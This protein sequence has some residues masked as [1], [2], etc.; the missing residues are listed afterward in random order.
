M[1]GRR[2]VR[3]NRGRFASTG[4]TARGGRLATA[5]GNKRATQTTKIAGGGRPAGTVGRGGRSMPTTAPPAASSRPRVRGDF[6]PRNTMAKPQAERAEFGREREQNLAAAGAVA[7][8]HGATVQPVAFNRAQ[9]RSGTKAYVVTDKQGTT[10][11]SIY[12]NK[13]SKTWDNPRRAAINSRRNG[14]FSTS[15]PAGVILH[16]VGH[17]KNGVGGA[18]FRQV[19]RSLQRRG[20]KQ[21]GS[22]DLARRVSKYATT[23]RDEFVAETFAGLKTGRKYD[24]QVMRAY[25]AATG[26]RARSVRSQLNK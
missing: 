14:Q 1:A 18:S 6:R 20:L 12:V 8:R 7:R 13:D 5:S 10:Y 3:D 11:S 21:P 2:Y 22:A 9:L 15:S 4:A 16:E 17:I 19:D 26:R 24:Y 25:R 23:N